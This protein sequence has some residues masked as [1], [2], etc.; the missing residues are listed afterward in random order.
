MFNDQFLAT[1]TGAA[2]GVPAC[3]VVASFP[4]SAPAALDGV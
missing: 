3:A 4:L 2:A 1:W